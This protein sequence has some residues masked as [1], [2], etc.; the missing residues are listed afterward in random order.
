VDISAV[1]SAADLGFVLAAA[2]GFAQ[3]FSP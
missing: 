3:L 2:A 1:L